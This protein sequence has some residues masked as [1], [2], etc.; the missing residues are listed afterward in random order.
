[1]DGNRDRLRIGE[2]AGMRLLQGNGGE[3]QSDDNRKQQGLPAKP[4]SLQTAI[5]TCWHV[6]KSLL[7]KII[8][9]SNTQPSLTQVKLASRL[10]SL[11][12]CIRTRRAERSSR[13]SDVCR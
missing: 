10:Q 11:P 4:T 5:S 6:F 3:I 12:V 7:I 13:I 2:F 9:T 1:M 8:T